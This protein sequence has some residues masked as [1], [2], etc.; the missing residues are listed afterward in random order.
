MPCSVNSVSANN[1]LEQHSLR[2]G[3]AAL[4]LPADGEALEKLEMYLSEIRLW[5]PRYKLIAASD[6]FISRHILDSLAPLSIM[7]HFNPKNIA[8]IGSGAGLPGIPLAIFL[9]QTCFSLIERSSR[10]AGFLHHSISL[11]GLKNVK[12]IERSVE[13]LRLEPCF[14]MITFRAWTALDASLIQ[15]LSKLLDSTGI[16]AAY[17]GRHAAARK[18]M[19]G[20]YE[21]VEYAEIKCLNIPGL[22]EERCLLLLK[23]HEI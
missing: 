1:V 2:N 15:M 6:D 17:R 23:P 21:S 7:R 8:D 16:I 11:L 9:P 5:N 14:D 12:I 20:I 19:D 18:E 10:R 13:E 22:D 3:L 4:E